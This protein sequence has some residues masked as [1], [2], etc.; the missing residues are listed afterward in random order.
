ME[1]E[2]EHKAIVALK[3]TELTVYIKTMQKSKDTSTL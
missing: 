1:A 3:G 2:G